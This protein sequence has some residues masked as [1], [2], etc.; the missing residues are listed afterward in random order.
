MRIGGLQ[1]QSFIDWD[2]RMV[3]VVF[4]QGCNFR[5]GY[6]HNPSL[7][8]PHLISIS[9]S[10]SEEEVLSFLESRKGWLD[11]VVISGGEPT[12]Q[13]C[14]KDFI[15]RIKQLGYAVKL[16]TNGTCPTLLKELIEEHLIDFVAMDIKTVP[17]Y[18]RYAQVTP[19]GKAAFDNVMQSM[20]LLEQ[21]TIPYQFRT[22]VIPSHHT[23]EDIQL[24]KQQMAT[25]P[26][27]SLQEFR[28]GDLVK[29]Y[30]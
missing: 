13:P 26:S 5:C 7:V 29:S 24:L 28:E 8:I 30:L 10:I 17:T 4:T 27:Y 11:G 18:E 21:G 2:G 20:Q 19:I 3:A 25:C 12:L 23:S 6:C 16:D 22:T 14:L 9:E 15:K 1:K